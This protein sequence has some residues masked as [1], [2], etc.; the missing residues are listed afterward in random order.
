[1]R[2]VN[3]IGVLAYLGK[4]AKRASATSVYLR[5]SAR[6]IALGSQP[7]HNLVSHLEDSGSTMPIGGLLLQCI[8]TL[9]PIMDV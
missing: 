7:H 4:D 6:S 2:N 5:S 1:M 3:D 9:Y 8:L